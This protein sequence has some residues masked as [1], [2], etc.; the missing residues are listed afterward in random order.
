[1]MIFLVP[2]ITCSNNTTEPMFLCEKEQFPGTCL[3]Y[4][5]VCNGIPEC[6]GG[7]DEAVTECGKGHCVTLYFSLSNK[8]SF[9]IYKS[10]HCHILS[11]FVYIPLRMGYVT[12][13]VL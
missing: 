1:M 12:E 8:K 5:K 9:F 3:P 11:V 6:P 4:D 7:Q 2:D 13:I 10:S